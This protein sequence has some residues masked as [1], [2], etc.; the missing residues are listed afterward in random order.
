M[1]LY[2]TTGFL[3]HE[4]AVLPIGSDIELNEENAARLNAEQ[5]NVVLSEEGQLQEKTV[6]ELREEAKAK[7]VKGYSKLTKDELVEA[8]K[9]E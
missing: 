1:P 7:G 5:E 4:G 3:I 8:L 2:K 6:D 9:E